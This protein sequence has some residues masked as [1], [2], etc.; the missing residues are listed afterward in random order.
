MGNYIYKKKKELNI[1]L[2][3]FEPDFFENLNNQQMQNYINLLKDETKKCITKI[4]NL[5]QKMTDI[6]LTQKNS[7]YTLNEQIDLINKDLTTLLQND[8]CLL[9]KYNSIQEQIKKNIEES[10][11]N[12]VSYADNSYDND[13][14]KYN[15]V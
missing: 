2:L 8:K 11:D 15:D 9:N 13:N 1:P 10:N 14:D 4:D 12:Y 6:N 5:E 7:I 3:T